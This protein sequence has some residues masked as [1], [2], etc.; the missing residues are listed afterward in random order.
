MVRVLENFLRGTGLALTL[1]FFPSS[2]CDEKKKVTLSDGEQ[3]NKMSLGPWGTKEHLHGLELW[4]SH[5]LLLV[6]LKEGLGRGQGKKY[7][8]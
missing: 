3:E 1:S 7:I 5:F 4:L 6:L 8:S 2:Y